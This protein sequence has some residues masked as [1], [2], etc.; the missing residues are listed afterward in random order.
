MSHKGQRVAQGCGGLVG[1]GNMSKIGSRVDEMDMITEG[2]TDH[3]I[4]P[5]RLMRFFITA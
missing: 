1:I 5:I 3:L 4:L 2:R